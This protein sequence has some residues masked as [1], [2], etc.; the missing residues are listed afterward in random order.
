MRHISEKFI[1]KSKQ[2]LYLTTFLFFEKPV[3]CEIIWKTTVEPGKTQMV[4]L[5]MRIACWLPKAT[6][7][8]S[9]YAIFIVFPQQQ[10]LHEWA[11]TW[12]YT[13]VACLF[14]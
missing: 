13:Y 7:T 12:R 11:L 4:T 6:N 9:E 8:R 14:K 10:W 2:I 5:H 3:F 1:E